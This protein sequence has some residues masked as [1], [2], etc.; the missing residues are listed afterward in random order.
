M[1]HSQPAN[2]DTPSNVRDTVLSANLYGTWPAETIRASGHMCRANRPDTCLLLTSAN[3]FKYVLLCRSNPHRTFAA[4]ARLGCCLCAYV[5]RLRGPSQSKRLLHYGTIQTV[6]AFGRPTQLA[7]GR[8]PDLLNYCS[9][10]SIPRLQHHWFLFDGFTKSSRKPHVQHFAQK[11]REPQH[12][13]DAGR[14]MNKDR[15]L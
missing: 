10:Q 2:Q 13:N 9:E 5:G 12:Q 6:P 7:S 14:G 3:A 1:A 15:C 8:L 11:Q 4:T